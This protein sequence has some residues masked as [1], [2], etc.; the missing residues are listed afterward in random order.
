MK[1]VKR[2]DPATLKKGDLLTKMECCD[3]FCEKL[4]ISRATYYREIYPNIKFKNITKEFKTWGVEPSTNF[5]RIPYD[6]VIGIINRLSGNSQTG[7]P[8]YP[9]LTEYMERR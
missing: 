9:T 6:V 4:R 5:E 1:Q 7:D 3:L 2:R 8:D